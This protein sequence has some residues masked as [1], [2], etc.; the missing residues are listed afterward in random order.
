MATTTTGG[1]LAT[2]R[3]FIELISAGNIEEG[4][5]MLTDDFVLD[6]AE[7]LPY[8]GTYHGR[9][10]FVEIMSKIGS[11]YDMV[12]ISI[13]YADAGDVVMVMP[14]LKFTARASGESLEMQVCE[15]YRVRD[16]QISKIDVYY[17]DAAAVAALV[18]AA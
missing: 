1:G 12:P 18:Q 11:Q 17:K 10:G 3:R 13:E 15:V 6:E 5:P 8:T 16:G 14:L 2:V 7:G 4:L 9:E